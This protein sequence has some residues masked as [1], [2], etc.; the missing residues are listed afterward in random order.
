MSFS[1]A[2]IGVGEGGGR[3]A[4]AMAKIGFNIGAINTNAGDL[5]G[6]TDISENKK[7]LLS[8]SD[9]GS[10]K[11]PNF[12]KEALKNPEQRRKITNFIASI[13]KSTP[14]FTICPHCSSEDKIKDTQAISDEH[15]CSVCNR[16]FNIK[17]VMH[18][19]EVKHNYLFLFACLG[20]GSGSGLLSDVI[21]ICYTNFNLPVAVICTLPSDNE[22]TISK[23][24][25]ISVFKELYNKYALPGIVSPFILVDN[26]KMMEMY[27][28][29]LGSMYSTI[30][31]SVADII[32]TFN[33]FTSRT[34][35]AGKTL[36]VTDAARLW[37]EGG[38]CALGKFTVGNRMFKKNKHE[39]TVESFNDYALIEEAM[40]AC[41]FVD[42]FD[43]SS[44]TG[45]GVIVVAPNYLLD[46]EEASNCIKFVYGRVKE[47][48]GDGTIY[49]VQYDSPESDCI[50]F[51]LIY[52]G[53]KYPEER[54]QRMWED[55]KA[56]K[57]ITDRKKNRIDGISYDIG[58]EA[59]SGGRNFHR[60]QELSIN[61]QQPEVNDKRLKPKPKTKICSNCI[62]DPF[63]KKSM[64]KYNGRGPAPFTGRICPICQGSGK[65]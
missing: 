15:V 40:A 52:N 58:L 3:L 13:L 5:R 9:G 17:Q 36:D 64:G 23:I 61:D 35:S 39:I 65:E 56:G 4:M 50:E 25:A 43:L 8:I 51:Y 63:T 29:P 28:L 20:G 45:V 53:L 37:A 6:L 21:D 31:N 46:T 44:A 33:D 54:F 18:R 47:I 55:V 38:C 2:G 10:G 24:N 27:N 42:G 26:Q 12:V 16:A 41:S 62:I 1:I 57:A 59:A 19:E 34:S 49:N 14:L 11:D 22:D 30:N 60:I 7:L 32:K 48:I